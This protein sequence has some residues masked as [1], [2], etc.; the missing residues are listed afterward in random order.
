MKVDRDKNAFNISYLFQSQHLKWCS[1]ARLLNM[2]VFSFFTPQLPSHEL[3]IKCIANTLSDTNNEGNKLK[4]IIRFSKLWMGFY[5]MMQ[6]MLHVYENMESRNR[7]VF[8]P[9]LKLL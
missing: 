6:L 7:S 4:N 9:S 5:K 3:Y 8:R 2:S 1:T